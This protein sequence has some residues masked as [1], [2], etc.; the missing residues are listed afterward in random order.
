MAIWFCM[1]LPSGETALPL[2]GSRLLALPSPHQGIIAKPEEVFG[3]AGRA[4]L[5]EASG[6]VTLRL[7]ARHPQGLTRQLV[8]QRGNA[9]LAELEDWMSSILPVAASPRGFKCTALSHTGPSLTFTASLRDIFDL[10]NALAAAERPLQLR[11][12]LLGTLDVEPAAMECHSL[13]HPGL[14]DAVLL[15]K[16]ASR[17]QNFRAQLVFGCGPAGPFIAPPAP[18]SCNFQ[19]QPPSIPVR[20]AK[21]DFLGRYVAY[22]IREA[23]PAQGGDGLETFWNDTEYEGFVA[24]VS[25]CGPRGTAA[26]HIERERERNEPCDVPNHRLLL[27]ADPALVSFHYRE[28]PGRLPDAFAASLLRFLFW[29]WGKR[30][31]EPDVVVAKCLEKLDETLEEIAS[32]C[33]VEVGG[34][35][36][37]TID[38]LLE[39]T[40]ITPHLAEA[41]R[42]CR[43][44]RRS[45]LPVPSAS[46]SSSL[47]GRAA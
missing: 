26:F 33:G 21:A 47:L 32:C 30:H 36:H 29:N 5:K 43:S 28:A 31:A 42:R 27:A 4:F 35:R 3:T 44:T 34:G 25:P 7:S 15:S 17:L 41:L 20:D 22:T 10:Y 24:D 1:P 2:A 39:E 9:W 8:Q 14:P 19:D 6:T 37:E 18:L 46:C 40:I 11:L 45:L 16:P 12:S 13:D 23:A 38:Q